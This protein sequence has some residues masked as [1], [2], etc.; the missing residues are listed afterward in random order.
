MNGV[1]RDPPS[2]I[3][4]RTAM[5]SVKENP[6]SRFIIITGENIKPNQS[7]IEKIPTSTLDTNSTEYCNEFQLLM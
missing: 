6:P 5:E 2:K 7:N 3:N 1:K 4:G